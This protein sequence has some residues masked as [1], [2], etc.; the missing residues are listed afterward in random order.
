MVRPAIWILW[1]IVFLLFAS[2][3]ATVNLVRADAIHDAASNGDM[4]TL[5]RLLNENPKLVNAQTAEGK[6]A[7]LWA[8]IR[9]HTETAKML[10]ESRADPNLAQGDGWA[11]LH[12]ALADGNDDR[13]LAIARLLLDHGARVHV[14]RND[15]WTPLLT[16]AYK[17]NIDG[18]SLLLEHGGSL[19]DQDVKESGPL[20]FAAY[21][22]QPSAIRFLLD[23][24]ADPALRNRD[25][26]TALDLAMGSTNP[27]V[28]EALAVRKQ[29]PLHV[30]HVSADE[31]VKRLLEPLGVPYTIDNPIAGDVTLDIDGIGLFR[32]LTAIL[33]AAGN[34]HAAGM[35]SGG[36]H[37]TSKSTAPAVSPTV[38]RV[39]PS[40][41]YHF[42]RTIAR[43]V[44][45]N[46]L[47]RA[48]THYGLCSTS[49]EPAS[50]YFDDDM[51]MLTSLG[52]KF[53]GRSAYA[54]VPPDDDEAHFRLAKE[55]ADRVHQIDPDIIL[56][57]A[58]FEAVYESVGRIP[59]PDWVFQEFNLPFEKRAFR[60][61]AMLYGGGKYRNH[62]TAGASVPDMTKI[63]TRMYFYYRARRYV[64]S[65]FEAIHFGQVHL[66]DEQDRDHHAWWDLLS[67]TR[68][69]A[70]QHARRHLV[71]CDAHTNG[72]VVDGAKLLFDYHAF[73]LI[74]Q[75][76][77]GQPMKVKLVKRYYNSIYGRSAGGITP[78]GWACDWAPY[79][80][81]F[82]C[83][84]SS[85]KPGQPS[86]FPYNWGYSCADWFVNQPEAYRK[87]YL[88]Y[89]HNWLLGLHED[90]WLQMPTRLNINQRVENQQM[91]H[92]NTR[93]PTCPFGF[94]LES[95]IKAIWQGEAQR[96]VGVQIALYDDSDR[97]APSE[98]LL[99]NG[100]VEQ[101][102]GKAAEGFDLTQFGVT[103]DSSVA[104]TGRW[105]VRTACDALHTSLFSS[106]RAELPGPVNKPRRILFRAWIRARNLR[107][108]HQGGWS[109][110]HLM[111]WAHDAKGDK[112]K[113]LN[114]NGWDNVGLGEI[115]GYFSGSFDWR[116][117]KANLV[118]PPG[119]ASVS[120]QG[121]IGWASGTA[122]FDDLSVKELPLAWEP[123]EDPNVTLSVDIAHTQPRPVEGIG[124]NWCFVW[125]RP[126]EM[127]MGPELV[128]QLLRYAAWDQQSFVRFGFLAQRC[129][130][131]DPRKAEPA[132]DA[133]KP[134]SIFY[135]NIL[136]GLDRLG[137]RI[138][139][140]NWQYGNGEAPY[141]KP[142]Y[143]ADRFAAA[144]GEPL[145]QWLLRDRFRGIRWISLWN[146]PDWW[147]KW[148]GSYPGDFPNYWAAMS[149]RL[150]GLGL[151]DRIGVVGADTTQ[152]GSIAAQAFPNM[153]ARTGSTVDAWS[154]HDYFSAVEAPG[155]LTSGGVLQPFLK[156]YAVAARSLELNGKSV[157]I[158]EFGCN[159]TEEEMS[160]R[161]TLGAA[162]LVIGGLNA[163]VRGF[164]RWI[165]N[166]ADGL[167][168]VN[169]FNP[170]ALV[171]G[172]LEPKRTIYYGYAVLTKAVRPGARVTAITLEGGKDAEGAQRVHAAAVTNPDGSVSILIANDGLKPKQVTI[173]GIAGRRLFHYWYDSTLPDGLQ[174]GKSAIQGDGTD[175]IPPMSI[176]AITTQEWDRL[177][178]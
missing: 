65:G 35:K 172:K 160:F 38:A 39:A 22:G 3:P 15:G 77:D 134:G 64:D 140:C 36:I 58:V 154:A 153:D 114:P 95:T 105:S 45:N 96:P 157:F 101:T 143:P 142:P 146:E 151:R 175:V 28:V 12:A 158:G 48:V 81:E 135:R 176:N 41:R 14:A 20:H 87:E 24:G 173:K 123:E 84:G 106:P 100:S 34:T 138:L 26:N 82:D 90:G 110:G 5:K 85:D 32:S 125:D 66:M 113:T 89:A 139:A 37:I 170:F 109:A 126:N 132:F 51:R 46:Y 80:C 163:G 118:V 78:S 147:Y 121:G 29:L 116:E 21:G 166:A 145:R 9:G 108:V 76:V 141:Q 162:E 161:G 25:G 79:I 11:P 72:V 16:A 88:A 53:I 7:L 68:K 10:L 177:K 144:V 159:R 124:W 164:A 174:R 98:E 27:E 127:K 50:A 150:R 13:H 168:D 8:A 47:S 55:R 6:T 178:P 149:D 171:N 18:I 60:Y 59:V 61:E 31:A 165:Y 169:G 62:W 71:L 33:R 69:Y 111:V 75:D 136:T 122:W 115:A 156:G 74:G 30:D 92:A 112:I 107:I 44:L 91:W 94:G 49:P 137:I 40:R 43:E 2:G 167:N 133:T 83:S 86:K 93:S 99:G 102:D 129:L 52:A 117:V 152:G 70:A 73:P 130:K 97:Q 104:H 42:D 148:G 63:E 131:E 56:Q 19:K 1:R 23:R 128:D 57:A 54:W 119:T 120:L 67:R 103:L 155:R 17:G 4:A